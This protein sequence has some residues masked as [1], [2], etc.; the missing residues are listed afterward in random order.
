MIRDFEKHDEEILRKVHSDS[1]FDYIFPELTDPLFIVRK[2]ADDGRT[3]QGIALKLEATVYLWLDHSWG[4]PEERWNVFREL[5]DAAKRAAWEKGLDTLT[6]VVPQEIA[7]TFGKRLEEIGMEQDR[8][9]PKWSFDLVA[10]GKQFG[11]KENM[12]ANAN[13]SKPDLL[14]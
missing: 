9:W 6:C 3:H 13:S 14:D 2:V 10:Y 5:T 11:E 12:Q 1:G 7:E 8:P 4:T